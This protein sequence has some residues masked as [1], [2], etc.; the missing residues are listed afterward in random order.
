MKKHH[1]IVIL[2]VLIVVV[3]SGFVPLSS[4]QTGNDTDGYKNVGWL[5]YIMTPYN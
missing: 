4:F 1:V 2:I 5:K 3:A